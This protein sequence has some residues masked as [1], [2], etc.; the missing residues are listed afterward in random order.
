MNKPTFTSIVDA[1]NDYGTKE[2][3]FQSKIDS[4]EIIT[5]DD[6]EIVR[7]SKVR[8]LALINALNN[9]TV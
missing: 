7:K 5:E 6:R 8:L 4:K 3:Q 2:R 9:F 1:V